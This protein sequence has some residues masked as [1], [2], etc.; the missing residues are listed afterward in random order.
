[1]KKLRKKQKK[2]IHIFVC[3][4]YILVKNKGFHIEFRNLLRV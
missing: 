4:N 2:M 1:M 3:N